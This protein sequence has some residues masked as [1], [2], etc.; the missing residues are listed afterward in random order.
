MKNKNCLTKRWKIVEPVKIEF[1]NYKKLK[2]QEFQF[3]DSTIYMVVGSNDV[4]KTTF[5]EGLITMLQVRSEVKVPVTHGEKDGEIRFHVKDDKGNPY[6]A[7]F[8]FT[9]ESGKFV[10]TSADGLTASQVTKIRDFFGHHSLSAEDFIRLG[11]NEKDRKKQRDIFLNLLSPE[12]LANFRALEEKLEGKMV[13]RKEANAEVLTLE[14]TIA[15]SISAEEM[16]ALEKKGELEKEK[17]SF[18]LKAAKILE[19]NNKVAVLRERERSLDTVNRTDELSE[20]K[21][22][23]ISEIDIEIKATEAKLL[24]LKERRTSTLAAYNE[25]IEKENERLNI[26]LQ[27][28]RKSRKKSK[29]FRLL[30]ST[31]QGKLKLK[32]CSTA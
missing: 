14:K 7:S 20:E 19:L 25:K 23:R 29:A 21:D 2:N 6:I 32:H 11:A 8:K 24:T 27:K 5:L 9:N 26:A 3:G 12:S 1:V 15:G 4:G 18:A 30:K 13:L 10:L 22:S 31:K 16:L 17:E 28:K